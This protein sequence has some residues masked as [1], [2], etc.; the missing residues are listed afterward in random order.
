MQNQTAVALGFLGPLEVVVDGQTVDPGGPKQRALLCYLALNAG[1]PVSIATLVEAVWGDDAPDGAIRSLRTYVSNLRRLLGPAVTLRGEQ[2]TYRLDLGPMETDIDRFRA[3]VTE[4]SDMKDPHES[5][6]MLQ[7]ALDLWRSSFL[8]D[9]DRP[10]VL[11]E[12]SVLEWERQR[13]VTMWVDATIAAGRPTEVIPVIERAVADAPLDEQLCGLAMRALYGSGRQADALAAYR[14]LRDAFARELGVEPGPE[15]RKLEEQILLHEASLNEAEPQW[16]LPSPA[17]DLVGR[18]VE[19]EDLLARVEQVRLLTLTG[20]GGVGKTRLAMEVG[21]RIFERGDRPVFFADLSTVFDE[22]A[23]DA[24]LALSAGVQP[25][26]DSGRLASLIEYLR[27]RN[28]LLI[29]DNCEHLAATVSRSIAALVR[30]CPQVTLV[31]TSRAALHIDGEL[32]W[33]TP[34]LALPD[35]VDTSIEELHQWAAV[36]LLLRRAPNAFLVTDANRADVVELCRSL[37]G[38]PLA[39]EIAASRLGSMTPAEIVATLGSRVQISRAGLPEDSRHETLDT[40]IGWSYELLSDQTRGLLDRLGVMS[41]RFL[42]EDVLSVCALESVSEDTVRDCMSSLVDQSLVMAETSGIR[43]RY[44]LLETIRRFALAR[45]GEDESDLRRRH[46]H[47]FAGLAEVEAARLLTDEEGDAIAELSTAHDNLRSAVGWAMETGD[48]ESASRIVASLPDGDYWRSRNELSRWAQWVWENTTPSDVRWRAVC[49]SAA[50]GAWVEGRFDDALRFGGEAASATGT[51]I[52]QCGYPADVIADIALYRGD[53]QTALE[54]YSRVA[55][56]ANEGGDLSREMWATY[57]IAV[58]NAVLGRATEA[59]DAA[60]RALSGARETGN[61]TA[62]AFSLYANG[63]AVKHRAPSEAIA[64][65]EEATR[66]AD[67]VRNDWIGGVARMELASVKAAHGDPEEGLREFTTVIDHWY[68]V[69]DDTQLRLAWRYLVRALVDVG[70]PDEAAILT[71]TLLTDAR[72]VLTHP[73]PLL[74]DQIKEA[75][76]DAEF[77]RLTVRGSVMSVPELVIV[78]L[79]AIDSV[80]EE[81]SGLTAL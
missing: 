53:A 64:M 72:S 50:R 9:V 5:S 45:L 16:L 49:G 25:H 43:T 65:F 56:E 74:L 38:L 63:L 17:A 59:A 14:R 22:T 6:T 52:A 28:A 41:G 47:Y 19:I 69:G 61:P 48:I 37:D 24:V 73:H 30:S 71:G 10:W 55:E 68:R 32:E 15:L 44:R 12:S 2:G 31:A 78:S 79:D 26:P 29:V 21:R 4:A 20:P 34:S 39:L 54:H 3:A 80:L 70:L 75:L 33:H 77:T 1:E 67:S 7:A 76:G 18:S 36:E 11:E 8:V 51:V 23:V 60:A 66:M 57:Y 13:A 42:L 81:G 46:T 40:T 27:P 35:R 58:T 62:L